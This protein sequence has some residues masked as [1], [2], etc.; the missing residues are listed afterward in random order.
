MIRRRLHILSP[1][2]GILLCVAAQYPRASAQG[3]TEFACVSCHRS[4]SESQPQTPM[5]R[6]LAFPGA[7]PSLRENPKLTARKGAYTYT[8]ETH[9]EESKYNVSDGTRTISIPIHWNFGVGRADLGSGARGA[10]L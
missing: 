7:N 6:A 3:K 8:V 2:A 5:G 10:P 4:R 1:L 9:G